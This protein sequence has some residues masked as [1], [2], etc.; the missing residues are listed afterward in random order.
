VDKQ[1]LVCVTWK[2]AHGTMG[3]A[4]SLHEIPHS[5]IEIKS[6]GLL[7]RQDEE[8]VS[9]ASE[10]CA[11]GTYRGYTFVPKGMLV[12]VEPVVKP[13]QARKPKLS[14]L[15]SPSATEPAPAKQS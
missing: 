15:Q 7:L 8:G 5:S 9:I 3:T 6:Y 13:K 12:S 11:D 4:L 14:Q 10:I 2:D 1:V